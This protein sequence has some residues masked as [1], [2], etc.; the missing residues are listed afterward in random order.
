MK[1]VATLMFC[2]SAFTLITDAQQ[3]DPSNDRAPV[4]RY[5]LL[6]GSHFVDECLVCGRPTILQPLR[7]TFDL[8]LVQDTPPFSRYLVRNIDFTASPGFAGEVR[9]IG[10]G[11]YRR[12]EEFAMV[13][14]MELQ[15]VVQDAYT[16]R[17]AFFTNN[18]SV[19]QRPFPLIE[20]SLTQTNGTLLQTFSLHLLAAPLRE[21]W[22]SIHKSL[23]STNAAGPARQISP[24]DL[25]S[26]HG[27]VVRRNL[28]LA[29]R[30]GVMPV[31]PDLGLDAV[32]VTCRGEILFS[33]PESV[34]SETLGQL[35]H[36][37]LLSD[38]GRIVK[39]NQELL[40]AFGL[41]A[42]RPDAGLDAVQ[43][44][45]DGEVLFS[46]QSN[47]TA[48]ASLTLSRGD[49]LS[50][51]GRVFRT[52]RELLAQFHPTVANRDYGLDALHVRPSGEIWFSVEEGFTDNALGTIQPGDL[53]S[54]LGYRVFG[55]TQLVVGFA[56]SDGSPDYGLDAVYLIT[57][58][59][60]SAVPPCLLKL[61]LDRVRGQ[62]RVE[63]DGEGEVF[64]LQRA[65]SPSGP[66]IPCST[67]VPDLVFDD[68]C[69]AGVGACHFYRVQQW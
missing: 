48:G 5:A 6:D 53:L 18:A 15:T 16:N 14:S 41:P 56:P 62:V 25:L 28:E 9:I 7:G 64:Q 33:I 30:M 17:M 57:D 29:A 65:E 43:V 39:R 3:T 61:L 54:S 67:I 20:I 58:T 1:R 63:W 66:W 24:G 8:V 51:R 50:D 13:Q 42:V 23:T 12:M 49:V 27:R 10:Q 38:R 69:P 22:F 4:V 11:T 45:L 36:G 21:V 46:I 68:P 19:V 2:F 55:N 44:M 47:V 37:D 40:A 52:N 31:V 60:V 59:K 35:Q 32:H 26:N 34:W